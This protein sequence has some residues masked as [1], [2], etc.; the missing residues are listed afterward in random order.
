MPAL[1]GKPR[2]IMKIGRIL[3]EA[4]GNFLLEYDSKLGRR[5]TIRLEAL[6]YE[7]ALRESRSYLGIG[8]D[9]RDTEGAEWD[10]E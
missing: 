6:T 4:A 2:T 3:D 8:D 1:P 10:I 9:A 7:A 5:H